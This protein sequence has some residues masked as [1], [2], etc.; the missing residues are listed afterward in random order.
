MRFSELKPVYK[1]LWASCEIRSADKG[2][3]DFAV[4][5]ILANQKRYREAQ[6]QSGVWWPVIACIHA[7]ESSFSF[8][9]H[10]HNGDP[11]SRRTVQVP[12]GRP[13]KGNPPFTWEQ[14]AADALEMK[15]FVLD[16]LGDL[17][18]PEECLYF[19]ELYNGFGYQTG[20]GRNTTPP[21]RSPYLWSMTT[22]YTRGKY[23]A[24]GRFD[25][26]AVSAQVGAAAMLKE[27][28]RRGVIAFGAPNSE[29]P[30]ANPSATVRPYVAAPLPLGFKRNL[31]IGTKGED[32]YR[33]LC[34]LIGLGFLGKTNEVTDVFN[35]VVFDAVSWFQRSVM[36]EIPDGIVGPRTEA[37]LEFALES[38]RS[39][40]PGN[41]GSSNPKQATLR[42]ASGFHEGAWAGLR[43]LVLTIGNETFSVASGAPGRQ[44]FRRPQDPRSSPGNLEPIPQGVYR[45]EGS[46]D[47]VNGVDSYEGSWGSGLGPVWHGLSATFSDDRG[48]FGIHEDGNIGF[49]QGSAG[50]VVFSSLS[51]L[52]KYVAAWRKFRPETLEVNWGL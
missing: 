44:N 16:E 6:K 8:S 23:V 32:V 39:G 43:K 19:L 5:Q 4:S 24:D 27:L 25:R 22:Q 11:L 42:R 20:A 14:S 3:V 2:Q 7:L 41:A 33:L 30:P 26:N 36:K 50:C 1:E 40:T 52:K 21:R 13:L 45:F 51:D 38:A 47:F 35:Q 48:N 9:G 18:T 49:A 17:D 37:A 34:A 28:E 29:T 31:E 10:L 46:P 12:A 15:R